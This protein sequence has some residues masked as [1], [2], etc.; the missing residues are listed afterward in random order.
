[1]ETFVTLIADRTRAPL[2]Q[3]L[4]HALMQTLQEAGT[5]I[6]SDWLAPQEAYDIR[7]HSAADVSVLRARCQTVVAAHAA[8]VDVVVQRTTQRKKQLLISD[9]DSTMIT[10]ECIDELAD[11]VGKKPEVARI[12]E[13][14][15]RGELDFATALRARVR[16]LKG[17]PVSLLEEV[18]RARVRYMPGAQQV[19]ATMR[20]SG[21]YAVL[22]SGGFTFFTE[23]VA[24]HLGF[25]AH[26]ANRLGV[27]GDTLSGEVVAP[28]MDKDSKR[29]IL[30]HLC[31]ERALCED[32]TL[33]V[34]D[35][36]NDI[37]MLCAAGLGVAYH[38]KAVVWRAAP[39]G[40]A[41]ADLRALLY[42]Q[43]Y[44]KAEI[45]DSE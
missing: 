24:Q 33:A 19:L 38:A 35:G 14:A 13:Q 2:P 16:L 4:V 30:M 9:M 5:V 27:D 20:R 12:T 26:H 15:M 42:M 37:P 29:A 43:G 1:M 18:Y 32:A 44:T 36:A 45:Y 34:G 39:V 8:P 22:V 40:I 28:I 6:A 3:T 7:L 31:K 11:Y 41:H 17:L 25:D 23:R 21:A 10:I